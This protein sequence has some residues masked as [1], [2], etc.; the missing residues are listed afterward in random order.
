MIC[1]Q[2]VLLV[3]VLIV[4]DGFPDGYF[5]FLD[6]IGDEVVLEGFDAFNGDL[7]VVRIVVGFC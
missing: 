1:Y 2:R 6:F 7:D 3:L 5:E 4:G